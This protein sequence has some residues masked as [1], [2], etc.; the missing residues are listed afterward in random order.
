MKAYIKINGKDNVLVALKDIEKG[1][2]LTLDNNKE[3]KL[4]EGIKRGHKIALSN[5]K[6]KMMLL[7]MGILLDMQLV[8]SVL[9]SGYI[10][11]I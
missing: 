9:V 1:T 11:I 8:I 3:I 2:V 7:N 4:K 10:L 5:I 6:K